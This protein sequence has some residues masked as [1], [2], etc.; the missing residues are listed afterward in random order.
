MEVG[1][2][3]DKDRNAVQPSRW[4]QGYPEASWLTGVKTGDRDCRAIVMW[5]CTI[6]GFLECY[7]QE[8]VSAPGWFSQ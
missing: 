2:G 4:L 1:F 6:C 7:A 3:L 5:R 8:Q